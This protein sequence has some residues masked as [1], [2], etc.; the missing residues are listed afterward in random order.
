MK[1]PKCGYLGFETVDRCRNCGYDFSLAQS[2][3]DKRAGDRSDDELT[4]RDRQETGGPLADLALGGDTPV[5]GAPFGDQGPSI[6]KSALDLDRLIGVPEEEPHDE[7]HPLRGADEPT[8]EPPRPL[9]LSNEHTPLLDAVEAESEGASLPLFGRH[10]NENERDESS[11]VAPPRPAG[12][13]LAVRRA[14]PDIARPRARAPRTTRRDEP[15]LSF[16]LDAPIT[17]RTPSGEVVTTSDAEPFRAASP[18]ARVIAAII[19]VLL[20]AGICAGV[21]YLTLRLADLTFDDLRVLPAVPMIAFLILLVV[22][23][24]IAFTAAGGQTIGKMTTGIRVISDDG[25]PVDIS[26]AVLRVAGNAVNIAT[27]GLA[28]L[29]ALFAQDGRS[30]A[31]RLAGTRVVR[32]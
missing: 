22:G 15:P 13:P 27:L 18:V 26:R 19:D 20:L 6:G 12:P 7:G 16:P 29:P 1:C 5:R 14:T 11:F 32:A 31:D 4:L 24:L 17:T 10:R 8:I 23:Y 9:A 21:L 28:W 3:A 30:L 25:R 2:Q